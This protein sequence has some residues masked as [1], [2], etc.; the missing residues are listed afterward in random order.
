MALNPSEGNRINSNMPKAELGKTLPSAQVR[1]ALP[2]GFVGVLLR[3][4][5]RLP[6]CWNQA[7]G[8]FVGWLMLQLPNKRKHYAMQ[9]IQ[10]CFPQLQ[11]K[12]QHWLWRQSHYAFGRS[13]A[14]SAWVWLRPLEQVLATV[15]AVEGEQ[16][17]L[18]AQQAGQPILL[19]TPHLGNW[20]LLGLHVASRFPLTSMYK[21]QK[22]EFDRF[23]QVARSRTGAHLVPS[24]QTGIK[25]QLQALRRGEAVG[26]LPD[27]DPG[28]NNGLYAPFFGVQA[29]SMFIYPRLLQ[30]TG[31]AGFFC[32][33]ERL[34]AG[35]GFKIQ[36]LP[37][38]PA[39]PT[40]ALP[41]ATALMNQGVE[42]CIRAIPQQYWWSYPRFRRRPAGEPSF[43]E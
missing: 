4:V 28:D 38:D 9:N 19:A 3:L 14:E 34:P 2:R 42:R 7:L 1:A 13:L 6:L 39:M 27:Q 32:F 22:G 35:R 15:K 41:A 24:D 5:A 23:M 33:A 11:P 12:Q 21:P 18:A 43:Y 31:A 30:K 8:G 10:A 17:V 20:E 26:M 25:A 16:A 40:A 29:N 37:V 36:Y